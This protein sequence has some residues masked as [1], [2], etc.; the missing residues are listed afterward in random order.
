MTQEERFG[1]RD[2]SYSAWHRRRSIRRF[3]GIHCAQTLAMIDLDACPYI[4]YDDDSKEPLALIEVAI[5]TGQGWKNHTVTKNLARM[6]TERTLPAYVVLYKKSAQDNPADHEQKDIESFRVM[7]I[8]PDPECKWRE[9][10]P[11]QWAR[12]LFEMRKASALEVD[13]IL[14]EEDSLFN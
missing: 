12:E 2:Q 13:R 14:K 9:L 10:T 11:S 5:D 6:C 8:W 4:E 1:T 3:V 7:R